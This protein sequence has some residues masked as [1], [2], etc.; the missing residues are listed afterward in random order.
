MNLLAHL[1]ITILLAEIM[2]LSQSEF[3]L[4]ILFGMVIDFDHLLKAPL[5]LKQN[6]LKIVRYWNWRTGLQEPVSYLWI[7]PIS[8]YLHTLV[9]IIFFTAHLILDYLCCFEKRPFYPF[10]DFVI[11]ER[12]HKTDEIFGIATVVMSCMLLFLV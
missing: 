6:G 4:A 10:S 7:I 12:R 9:P 1:L 3:L 2:G 5:Y 8:F 11:K